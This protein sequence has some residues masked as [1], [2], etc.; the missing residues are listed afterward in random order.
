MNNSI[1][2]ISQTIEAILFATADAYTVAALAKLLEVSMDEIES[3]LTDL[4]SSLEGH[5]IMIV[6][7]GDTITLATTSAHSALLETLRK[8]ELQ[9]DLSKASAETLAVV[10]YHPGATKPEIELIRGVNASYSLRALQIRGLIE[11][12]NTGR[13]VSY[14]P[15]V[16]LLESYGVSAI[17]EL[18]LYAETKQKIESLLQ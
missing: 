5:G 11:T 9:K 6:R 4:S 17:E 14:H 10:T 2:T 8:E 1:S 16:A 12:R 7:Q 15:T 3:G 18:P 13:A